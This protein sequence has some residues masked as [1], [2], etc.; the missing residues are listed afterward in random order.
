MAR[1]L[2]LVS[3]PLVVPD[4]DGQVASVDPAVA[5]ALVAVP[6]S[7]LAAAAAYG[8]GRRQAQGAHAAAVDAVRRPQQREAYLRLSK[9][10]RA[11]LDR[12]RRD[13]LYGEVRFGES[14]LFQPGRER[15]ARSALH[16]RHNVR[17]RDVT[18]LEEAQTLVA[19]EGASEV[20]ESSRALM[21]RLAALKRQ[22]LRDGTLLAVDGG[23]DLD[24]WLERDKP[25]LDEAHRALADYEDCVNRHLNRL[26]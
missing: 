3:G 24:T 16:V 15:E 4:A 11:Y 9:E 7:L 17:M 10:A 26:L 18:Q 12:A 20:V 22:A 1:G 6:S 2:H 19:V 14:D 23:I 8:A 5:A 25:L 13:S 21:S